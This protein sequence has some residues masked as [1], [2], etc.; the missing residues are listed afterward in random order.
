MEYGFLKAE[1]KG[2][3]LVANNDYYMVE[4]VF[5]KGLHSTVNKNLKFTG[6]M[7]GTAEIITENRSMIERIYTPLKLLAKKSLE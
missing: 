5:P 4:V 3:S 1:T 2:I 6:E 7:N